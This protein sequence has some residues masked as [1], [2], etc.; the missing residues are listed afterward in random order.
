MYNVNYNGTEYCVMTVHFKKHNIP[1]VIDAS[2]ANIVDSIGNKWSCNAYGV[3]S[4]QYKLHDQIYNIKLHEL[5]MTIN[6]KHLHT[7]ATLNL[8][9]DIIKMND[10]SIIH[11]NKMG[12]DNR[13]ENLMYDSDNKN[14]TKNTKKK[15]R[16]IK[17]PSDSNVEPDELPSYVWFSKAE[18]HMVIVL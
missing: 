7:T 4:H 16:I 5:I 18:E 2:I 3:I 15:H 9:E 10:K 12:L 11:I 14:I 6:N 13:L 17:L 1:V 8:N